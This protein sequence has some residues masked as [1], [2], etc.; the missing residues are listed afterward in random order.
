VTEASFSVLASVSADNEE[1]II[2]STIRHLNSNGVGVYLMDNGSTDR[3][4]DAAS[5]WLGRGLIGI[6]RFEGRR[7][8]H[9]DWEAILRRQEEIA[10]EYPASWYIHHDADEIREGPWPLL[11][12]KQA[13]QNVDACGF[14]CIDFEVFHFRP[15]DNGYERGVDPA[16]Y[17]AF[18][19]DAE[20]FDQLQLRCWKATP[21]F[22]LVS[23]GGHDVQFS[24]RRVFPVKFVLRHYPIRSEPHGRRKVF[25]ERLPR[26]R[27]EERA[28]GWHIHYARFV[29]GQPKL[30][31]D[32]AELILFDPDQVRLQLLVQN[33]AWREERHLLEALAAL[34]AELEHV[35]PELAQRLQAAL[36]GHG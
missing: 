1:D 28:R 23:L 14:N 27:E 25:E 13:I 32:P 16:T 8:G 17:F 2:E 26:F 11:N 9:F 21:D 3:T 18:Y 34:K 31:F 4:I 7:E 36:D 10:H 12:L 30:V 6:E 29:N 35:D 20:G 5:A 15:I 19:E 24:G 22:D 33:E